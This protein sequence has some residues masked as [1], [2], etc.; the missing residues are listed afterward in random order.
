MMK[1]IES[2]ENVMDYQSFLTFVQAL[3]DDWE[4]E[5]GKEKLRPNSP[6]GP[7]ANGWEH[8]TISDYLE[9]ALRCEIDTSKVNGEQSK[10][11]SW[12]EFAEF[13]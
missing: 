8:G 4:D 12:R 13:L 9:A 11:P 7:G 2:L 10:E 1:L 5:V 3:I 6:Y